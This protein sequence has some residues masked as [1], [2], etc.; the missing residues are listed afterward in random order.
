MKRC[1]TLLM[2]TFLAGILA[3]AG[4]DPW[5]A[6]PYA[7]WNEQDVTEVLQASPWAK[8]VQASGAWH[9]FDSRAVDNSTLGIVPGGSTDGS[10]V[11]EGPQ[12]GAPG[13]AQNA[14]NPGPQAYSILWWSSRTVRAASVRRAVLKGT[15]KEEDAEKTV[16]NTPAEYMVLVQAA[17]MTIFQKRGEAAFEKAGYIQTKRNKQKIMPSHVIFLK[18]SDG[19]T[20]TA[21]VFHFPKKDANGQP[22]ISPDE[23]EI[24]FYV[25]VGDAKLLTYFDPRKMVDSQGED[26]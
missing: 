7:Q 4:D 9:P 5:K 12:N 15:M 26:L 8:V 16:V 25:Q 17:N 23:K 6:K 19:Q 18:A 2:L 10:K 24:D 1:A 11:S 14:T 21:A 22:T 20:V 3:W 13:G